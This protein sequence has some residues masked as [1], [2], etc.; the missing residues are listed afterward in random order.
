M[1]GREI[2]SEPPRTLVLGVGNLLLGDE[3]FGVHAVR[4]LAQ[5]GVPDNVVLEDGG[6]G[7]VD[8]LDLMTAFDRVILIDL[9]RVALPVTKVGERGTEAMGGLVSGGVVRRDPVPGAVVVFRLNRV[10]LLNPDPHLSLHGCSLGGLI[11]L[12]RALDIEL[13]D[14]TVIGTVAEHVGWTTEMSAAARHAAHEAVAAV[15][16]LLKE[17]EPAA[18]V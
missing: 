6:T 12:A 14:I 2:A 18:A 4:L 17:A 10:E 1:P 13:P 8:L 5:E 16:G 7:G 9:L 3:G 11:R 15:R